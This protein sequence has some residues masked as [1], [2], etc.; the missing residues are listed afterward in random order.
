MRQIPDYRLGVQLSDPKKISY[1][2]SELIQ[3]K[4]YSDVFRGTAIGE[5][6][7][8]DKYSLFTFSILADKPRFDTDGFASTN[9]RWVFRFASAYRDL[10]SL[11]ESELKARTEIDL[12]G[13][14]ALFKIDGIYREPLLN[15]NIFQAQPILAIAPD[16]KMLG[17]QDGNY[18]DALNISL[19]RKWEFFFGKAGNELQSIKFTRPPRQKRIQYKNR[20][21]TCFAGSVKMQGKDETLKFAQC[22]GLGHLTSCG[23]GMLV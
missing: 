23:L 2:H 6:V 5:K 17:P 1:R 21:L 15:R 9:G 12:L 3:R 20:N 18:F 11:L 22:V 8:T 16:K 10:L 19:L 13:Q 14:G 4:L 7:H